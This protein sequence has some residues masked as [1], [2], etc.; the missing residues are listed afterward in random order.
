MPLYHERSHEIMQ[1]FGSHNFEVVGELQ[2]RR[3]H[4]ASERRAHHHPAADPSAES[5]WAHCNDAVNLRPILDGQVRNVKAGLYAL[6]AATGCLLLIACLNIA[7]LLVA[8]AA[9]RGR[10]TAIRTAL[11]GSRVALVRAQVIESLLLSLAGGA[12]GLALAYGAVAWLARVRTDLPRIDAI[13]IDGTTALFAAGCV[14][15]C[16]IVAGMVP[17]LSAQDRNL[18]GALQESSRSTSAGRGR[19]RMR[20]TLLTVEVGLT[21]VLLIAAGLLR[22]ELSRHARLGSGL[23]H[24]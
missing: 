5:G 24:T 4:G 15:L 2:A 23:R 17:A 11:G 21:V 10:E 18:V 7:N 20:R 8:R 12:L 19:A 16:G 3:L 22:E 1:A 13:H 9:S 6:L 14:L